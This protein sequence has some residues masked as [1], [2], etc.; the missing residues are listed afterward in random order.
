MS[1]QIDITLTPITGIV[2]SGQ[3][4]TDE[5]KILSAN[6][7]MSKLVDALKEYHDEPLCDWDIKPTSLSFSTV[8]RDDTWYERLLD[9]TEK[10]DVPIITHIFAHGGCSYTSY[11]GVFVA[12]KFYDNKDVSYIDMDIEEELYEDYQD[13]EAMNQGV[14]LDDN[15]LIAKE[16]RRREEEQRKAAGANQ[17]SCEDDLPF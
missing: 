15:E 10:N 5:N 16:E 14:P 17:R 2:T 6:P 7:V 9:F 8:M 11:D 1:T 4:E 3:E 13:S 12:G